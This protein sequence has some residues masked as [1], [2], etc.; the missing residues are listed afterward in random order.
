MTRDSYATLFVRLNIFN[1]LADEPFAVS[2]RCFP[3]LPGESPRKKIL[4]NMPQSALFPV[5]VPEWIHKSPAIAAVEC[6]VDK[7]FKP[8]RFPV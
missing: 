6:P 5:Q 7:P 1:L 2:A 4:E 3:V 8:V